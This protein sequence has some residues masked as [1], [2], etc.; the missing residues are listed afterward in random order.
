MKV[1]V[2]ADIHSNFVA[3]QAAAEHLAAWKPDHV[4]LAG[5]LVNRGPRPVECLGYFQEQAARS[6]W[7]AVRG[8]HEDYVIEQANH[9]AHP[10]SP[11]YE[12]HRASHWTYQR[13]GMD[14]RPLQEM[15]FQQSLYAPDGSELR[16]VH[17]SMRGIRDG[18]Y[19]DTPD[20]ALEG[21]VAPPPAVLCV[22]HTH[23]SLIRSLNGTL[24]V[25]AGSVGLPFDENP[26]LAYAQVTWQHGEWRAEIIRL[27]YDRSQ[28]RA[29]FFE[30]GYYVEAGPLVK[31]VLIELQTARSMLFHWSYLYQARAERGLISMQESVDEFIQQE[32]GES[33]WQQFGFV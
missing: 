1:A 10:S 12:V 15:P 31:L 14:T 25:N 32:F 29:D 18:I 22:G 26:Q 2:L 21:Q 7:L 17:A 19:V 28:A 27:Q 30:Q 9:H 11:A 33:A 24:V 23:R 3:F 16:V 20:S 6:G 13:L 8:N 5:D 4:I